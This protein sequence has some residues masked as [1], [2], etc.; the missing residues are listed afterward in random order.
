MISLMSIFFYFVVN[1]TKGNESQARV[2]AK[3]L[4]LQALANI[5]Y[6]RYVSWGEIQRW[7]RILP[8][9]EVGRAP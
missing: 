6:T 9:E 5:F 1:V 2:K 8:K 4:S 7:K 3:E